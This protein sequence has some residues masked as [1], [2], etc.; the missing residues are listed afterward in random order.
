[1]I[2]A[3]V[4]H[5]AGAQKQLGPLVQSGKLSRIVSVVDP[6]GRSTA[7][8]AIAPTHLPAQGSLLLCGFSA[9]CAGVR[10]ALRE[11]AKRGE[12]ARV[13]GVVLLD[14]AHAA[15]GSTA[16]DPKT[17]IYL[18][19]GL[20]AARGGAPCYWTA[21]S[22][23]PPSFA[24]TRYVLGLLAQELGREPF[25]V[26]T[27]TQGNLR[28]V[29]AADQDHVAQAGRLFDGAMWC[30]GAQAESQPAS[31]GGWLAVAL[32]ALG[33]GWLLRPRASS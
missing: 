2:V 29:V 32:A 5:H 23:E 10:G 28:V 1:M 16:S 13:A 12:L 19:A 14:G 30:L 27:T 6:S 4:F 3:V 20:R 24:S 11:L 15:T 21:S 9:G 26:G 7:Y 8:E 18:G 31:G 22:I 33:L 25:A 17:V